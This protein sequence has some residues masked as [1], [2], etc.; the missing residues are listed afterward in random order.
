MAER[1][2]GIVLGKAPSVGLLNYAEP[3]PYLRERRS[4]MAEFKHDHPG[5]NEPRSHGETH[6][7][8]R[9]VDLNTA[10]Q[11]E[12]EDLPMVGPERARKLMD[13]RPFRSWEDVERVPGFDRGMID[14][15]K[16]G[17]AQ[18]GKP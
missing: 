16:S 10:S 13:A 9:L 17:G 18:L 2:G 15:L 14:D 1:A 11:Q 5:L 8:E 7:E 4:V 12:L 3:R 6:H